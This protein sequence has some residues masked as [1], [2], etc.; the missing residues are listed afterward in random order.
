MALGA[1]ALTIVLAITGYIATTGGELVEQPAAAVAGIVVSF[2]VVPAVL[3]GVSLLSLARYRLRRS[4]ID[5]ISA[6]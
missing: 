5:G 1:T 2:S 4:D 6:D 3:I